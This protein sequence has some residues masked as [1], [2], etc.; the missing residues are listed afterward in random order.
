MPLLTVRDLSTHFFTEENGGTRL[1]W[2]MRFDSEEEAAKLKGFI[3]SANEEN[4][5]RL[6]THLKSSS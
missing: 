2:R 6:E 4:F 1:T 3:T 5:D